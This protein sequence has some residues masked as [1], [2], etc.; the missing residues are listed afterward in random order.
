[1]CTPEAEILPGAAAQGVL[2]QD[3]VTNTVTVFDTSTPAVATPA[4]Q[5]KDFPTL[6]L[7]ESSDLLPS[8]GLSSSSSS[9][10]SPTVPRGTAEDSSYGLL[11]R[12]EQPRRKGFC[13]QRC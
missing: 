13:C 11:G 5:A 6:W 7:S 1:M 10:S 2:P 3:T 4:P 9:S 8:F 12:A